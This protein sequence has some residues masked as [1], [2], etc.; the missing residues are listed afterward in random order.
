MSKLPIARVVNATL[1][2][3]VIARIPDPPEMPQWTETRKGQAALAIGYTF[4][5]WL[6]MDVWLGLSAV[7]ALF[8][9]QGWRYALRPA[10]TPAR[11][12]GPDRVA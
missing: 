1:L 8:A 11:L 9:V 5:V 6:W 4:G 3:R 7:S 10:S 12:P 2:Q